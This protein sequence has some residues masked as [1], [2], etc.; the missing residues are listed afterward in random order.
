MKRT[1]ATGEASV[2]LFKPQL[3]PR[4][5]TA[6]IIG[7]LRQAYYMEFAV[8]HSNLFNSTHLSIPYLSTFAS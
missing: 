4:D 7:C 6:H 8:V 3:M 2:K 1:D 5:E